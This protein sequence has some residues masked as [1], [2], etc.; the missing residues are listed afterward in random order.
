MVTSIPHKEI[1]QYQ[2]KETC[3]CVANG[4][5]D[6]QHQLRLRQKLNAYLDEGL[7]VI[8]N[9]PLLGIATNLNCENDNNEF[10]FRCLTTQ[11][12]MK[13]HLLVT[14]VTQPNILYYMYVPVLHSNMINKL[15]PRRGVCS[16]CL[17]GMLY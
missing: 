16:S 7:G 13:Q 4:K 5:I 17:L 2:Q 14:T 6:T 11:P 15:S 12:S 3:Y 1:L 9:V 10:F 8:I